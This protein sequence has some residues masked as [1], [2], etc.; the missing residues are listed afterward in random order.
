MKVAC[1][2]TKTFCAMFRNT[3]AFGDGALLKIDKESLKAGMRGFLLDTEFD[4]KSVKIDVS[5]SELPISIIANI[6]AHV[7]TL[8]L[9]MSEGSIDD[10]NEAAIVKNVSDVITNTPNLHYLRVRK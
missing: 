8:H 7:R 4:W 10:D 3:K 5:V 1:Q 2:T 6:L 9:V